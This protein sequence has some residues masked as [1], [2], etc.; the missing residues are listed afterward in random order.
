MPDRDA[1]LRAA[2]AK[3]EDD[4]QWRGP[5]G[6]TMAYVLLPRELAEVVAATVRDVIA[7]RDA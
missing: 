2:L 4:L 6:R 7:A 1:M 3:M 5:A